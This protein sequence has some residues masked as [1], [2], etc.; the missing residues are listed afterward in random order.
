[1]AHLIDE[2]AVQDPGKT[3]CVVAKGP[4]V[5]DGFANFTFKELAHAVNYASWWIERKFGRSS[6]YETLTYIGANDI[7]YLVFIVA[8][9]KTGYKVSRKPTMRI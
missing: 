3:A 7:R 2:L 4:E 8:C 9:N 5:E 6:K 1:M